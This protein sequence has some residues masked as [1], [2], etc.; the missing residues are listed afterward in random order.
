MTIIKNVLFKACLG[1][2]RNNLALFFS[3]H[4][5]IWTE[6]SECLGHLETGGP[7]FVVLA[8]SSRPVSRLFK[9]KCEALGHRT[10]ISHSIAFT[11]RILADSEV[12]DRPIRN[13]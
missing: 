7:L 8:R 9:K 2:G 13:V 3:E 1:A 6:V 11:I 12:A 5:R 4:R 10:V